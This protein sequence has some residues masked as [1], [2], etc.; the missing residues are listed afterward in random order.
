MIRALLALFVSAALPVA[1]ALPASAG[2]MPSP[3]KSYGSVTAIDNEQE[4]DDQP[5]DDSQATESPVS[6]QIE[7]SSAVITDDSGYHMVLT[8]T[9]NS[10]QALEAGNVSLNTNTYYTFISRTD[11]QQWAQGQTRIPTPRQ[12]AQVDLPAL[13]S[14]QSTQLRFDVPADNQILSSAMNW[15]PKPLLIWAQA[16]QQ[17]AVSHTFVTKAN[18]NTAGATPPLN[19]TVLLPMSDSGWQIN[20]DRLELLQSA[21]LS[22]SNASGNGLGTGQKADTNSSSGQSAGS[23]SGTS[24]STADSSASSGD[25]G[26]AGTAGTAVGTDGANG[27]NSSESADANNGAASSTQPNAN[28]NATTQSEGSTTDENTDDTHALTVSSQSAAWAKAVAQIA[29]QHPSLQVVSDPAYASALAIPPSSQAVMQPAAFDMTMYSAVNNSQSYASAGL[30]ESM[31]SAQRA[32]SMYNQATGSTLN[33][34]TIAWQGQA[35]WTSASLAQAKRLGYNAVVAQDG[36]SVDDNGEGIV[37]TGVLHAATDAGDITILSVQDVLSSLAQGH[38]TSQE[39]DGEATQAGR[40]ARFMAQS[41]FYQMEQPYTDRTLV[42]SLGCSAQ[43]QDVAAI[44]TALE[45]ASWLRLTSL[46]ET[47][48]TAP[49]VSAEETQ[50]MVDAQSAQQAAPNEQQQAD[51]SNTANA[52]STLSQA[53]ADINRLGSAIVVS[54]QEASQSGKED[55]QSLARQ[56]ATNASETKA[57]QWHAQLLDFERDLALRALSLKANQT[58][59]TEQ[60]AE[61]SENTKATGVDASK[62]DANKSDANKQEASNV[63]N[64]AYL[65]QTAIDFAQSL[66]NSVHISPTDRITVVTETATMPVTVRN[67]LP[68]AVRISVLSSTDAMTI[69]TSRSQQVLIPARGDTQTT[70]DI[71]VSTS[72][73]ATATLH[74][75]DRNG[76][77]FGNVQKTSITST[78]QISDMSGIAIIVFAIALGILG[79]WRQFHRVKDP[80]E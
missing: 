43:S 49:S 73:S 14:G 27:T 9:N 16:G 80:D 64:R 77:P 62:I 65:A 25:S 48:D 55:A 34:P 63:T 45:Q 35:Q 66:L 31:W 36:Y 76:T 6:L 47:L 40:I 75:A 30:E 79:L 3:T 59:H 21:Q 13:E 68:F 74:M 67:D 53:R 19:M 78:L 57:T 33:L 38:A 61:N 7:Q 1:A 50:A 5:T 29:Q 12:L 17:S 32:Q 4:S 69:V 10:D 54:D 8:V 56:D 58:F 39:A 46:H 24:P 37:R 70:F 11:L 26:T 42:V 22:S 20:S 71:R 28:T 23:Q 51:I 15:G 18:N 41:A 52:L 60:S 2:H 72:S 44:A